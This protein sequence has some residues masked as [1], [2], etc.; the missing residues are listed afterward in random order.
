[1]LDRA[2]QHAR[3]EL[4]VDDILGGVL[5]GNMGILAQEEGGKLE[6]LFTFEII[7]YPRCSVFN[8]IAMAGRNLAGLVPCYD[9]IDS[10][11]NNMG[12]SIVRCFC[13]PSVA[14]RIKQLFPDTQA[15]YVVMERE[16]H[17]AG[18]H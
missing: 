4:E 6:L 13:R 15:A 3:G 2:I 9:L 8:I 5:T 14:R 11:A 7:N 12:A 10:L 16:V 1:M 18:L 17:H